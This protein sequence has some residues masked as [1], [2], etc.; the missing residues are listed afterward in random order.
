MK[1]L[2][3]ALLLIVPTLLSA[4]TRVL[5]NRVDGQTGAR[6]THETTQFVISDG[7]P[8]LFQPQSS[9]K[10]FKVVL[11]D[12]SITGYSGQAPE[13]SAVVTN[14]TTHPLNMVFERTHLRIDSNVTSGICLC[15]C[16][17]DFLDTLPESSSC[18]LG[19]STPGWNFLFHPHCPNAISGQDSVVDYIKL[20]ALTGDPGDTVSFILKGV[21]LP[22]DNAVAQSNQGSSGP[23]IVAVYPSPLVQGSTIK[24]RISSPRES[25]LSYSIYDGVGRVIGLGATRQ[26]INLGDNTISINSLD[27]L[28]SGSY[29]LK[30]NFGDGST[31][32]HFF[33]VMR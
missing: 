14:N 28:S 13:L 29:M 30:L 7:H 12:S 11:S 31:D 6:I 9:E 26:H 15:N 5:I 33:Q 18:S 27:G 2:I 17:A 1:K 32:T 24:V 16:Y 25:T 20:R 8:L 22:Q 4:Q 3:I 19:V 21:F 23:K 10:S